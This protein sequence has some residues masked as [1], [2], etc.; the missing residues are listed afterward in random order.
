MR[1]GLCLCVLALCIATLSEFSAAAHVL[2]TYT[3][4]FWG[5]EKRSP[6]GYC[7]DKVISGESSGTTPL[8][9]PQDLFVAGDG[10]LYVADTD[11]HRVVVLNR[12]GSFRKEMTRFT[13]EDGVTVDLQKPTGIFVTADGEILIVDSEKRHTLRCTAEGRVLTI[14][15]KPNTQDITFTGLDYIPQ[16]V[17]ADKSGYVFILCKDL[18]QGTMMYTVD[19]EFVNYFGANRATLTLIQQM[20]QLYKRFMTK[21]QR[22]RITRVIPNAISNIDIDEHDFLYTC[23]SAVT[24]TSEQLRRLN[25][26]GVN[27]MESSDSLKDSFQNIFGDLR[28]KWANGQ[29]YQTKL[30]DVAYD[31]AGLING[32][33]Q[34]FG[35]IFQYDLEGHLVFAFGGVGT[36]E[37]NFDQAVAID[38]YEG[39]LYVLD[40]VK[41]SITVFKETD[42]GAYIHKAIRLY[43]DGKYE[44]AEDYW[45]SV[46]DLNCNYTLTYIGLGKIKYEQQDYRAAMYYFRQGE[47]RQ[48]YGNAFKQ[49]RNA[50]LRSYGLPVLLGTICVAFLIWVIR[51]VIHKIRC[52]KQTQGRRL[53]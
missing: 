35:R 40:S 15:K 17:V 50:F 44:E 52:F 48:S 6:A 4:D 14:Y 19:G 23:T 11:N 18:Y 22:E 49:V 5:D 26:K 20:Q 37:G 41:N 38:T 27:I 8:S 16:K 7:V 34:T 51:Y 28:M 1:K 13:K 42:Y 10:S 53:T 9:N 2:N 39:N 46:I 12:D 43:N 32:I 47:D 24:N 45:L 31:E 36:Q 30:V 3:Y 21:E 33:D 29:L 25:P